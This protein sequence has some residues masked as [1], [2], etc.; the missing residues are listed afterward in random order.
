MDSTSERHD[1]ELTEMLYRTLG[2]TGES[3][4]TIGERRLAPGFEHVDEQLAIRIVRSAIDR[5]INFL[6]TAGLQRRPVSEKR[7]GQALR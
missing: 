3:V 7:M 4:V 6:T 2:S 5:G 1:K